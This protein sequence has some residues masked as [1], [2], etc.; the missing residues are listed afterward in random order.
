MTVY[1]PSNGSFYSIKYTGPLVG[2]K[3]DDPTANT[4]VDISFS[5]FPNPVNDILNVECNIPEGAQTVFEIFDVTGKRLYYSLNDAGMKELNTGIN[6]R[7]MG[8]A[9]G[10]YFL[11]VSSSGTRNYSKT[12]KFQVW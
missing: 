1:R 4:Q 7:E 12:A 6:V 5:L 10:I 2:I 3:K 11:R 8:L 9:S